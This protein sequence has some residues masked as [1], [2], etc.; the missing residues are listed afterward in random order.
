MSMVERS[1]VFMCVLYSVER[2]LSSSNRGN[3]SDHSGTTLIGGIW[4][5]L[6]VDLM[7][8][9]FFLSTLEVNQ[10]AYAQ[11]LTAKDYVVE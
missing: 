10:I 5:A 6:P 7:S 4:K 1:I 11:R 2:D 9:A 8:F 3:F